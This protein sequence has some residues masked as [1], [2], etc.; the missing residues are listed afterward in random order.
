MDIE[1]WIQSL[2]NPEL[3][4]AGRQRAVMQQIHNVAKTDDEPLVDELALRRL[5][6]RLEA[7]GWY[8]ESVSRPRTKPRWLTPLASAAVLLLS[9]SLGLEWLLHDETLR[10]RM[11][12]DVMSSA[13]RSQSE[14]RQQPV[15]QAPAEESER[16]ELAAEPE[17]KTP[18]AIRPF[19]AKQDAQNAPAL[20][21][22][23]RPQMAP[24]KK[25]EPQPFADG[26]AE[27][28]ELRLAQPAQD[29][30]AAA[31]QPQAMRESP[32]NILK[33]R[34]TAEQASRF[35][36]VIAVESDFA[37]QS[38]EGT[39]LLTPLTQRGIDQLHKAF[40]GIAE[41]ADLQSGQSY[42]LDIQVIHD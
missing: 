6:Q 19:V 15:M 9:V 33:L 7:E 37:M 41:L 40:P 42:Q 30:L 12:A 31:A 4:P 34:L 28:S 35:D 39:R 5:H 21:R 10:T 13:P 2:K 38:Q 22:R 24:I 23:E 14:Q 8:Q 17:P 16:P 26:F 18:A 3:A 27:E 11:S 25:A 36:Q 29:S 20:Q 32:E 1:D